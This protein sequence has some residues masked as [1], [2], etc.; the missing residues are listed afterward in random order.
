LHIREPR[1]LGIQV[2]AEIVASEYSQP[3]VVRT[4]AEESLQHL[5]TPLALGG[6]EDILGPD[7]EGWPFG[8]DLYVSEIYSLIQK[9]PGVKHVLDVRLSYRQVI[10]SQER[11]SLDSEASPSAEGEE[12]V[13]AGKALTKADQKVIPIA[14]DMLCCSL[15]HNIRIVEL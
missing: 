12:A 14:A 3:E 5:L 11:A 4:K 13:S 9:V 8:R 15:E 1:Y 6:Y 2:Q 7:W 10:P